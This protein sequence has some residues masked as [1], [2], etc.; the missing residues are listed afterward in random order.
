MKHIWLVLLCLLLA[1]SSFAQTASIADTSGTCT[2]TTTHGRTYGG[3][4]AYLVDWTSDASGNVTSTIRGMF[5]QI[6]RVTTNPDA[7]AT[8][9]TAS[10]DMT[11]KDDDEIDVLFG[12]GADLSQSASKTFTCRT[13]DSGTTTTT[14]PVMVGTDLDLAITSAG[15]AKSGV[16]RIYMKVDE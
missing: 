4:E 16:I 13:V 10:Y 12:F 6:L 7:G 15:N 11:L 3:Y 14:I 2:I 8:S 9:P 5:G 1:A